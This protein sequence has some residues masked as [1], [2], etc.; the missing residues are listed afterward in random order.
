MRKLILL[1]IISL[2]FAE[3]DWPFTNCMD[4]NAHFTKL[5]LN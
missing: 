4:G 5:T 1:I 2:A 3:V